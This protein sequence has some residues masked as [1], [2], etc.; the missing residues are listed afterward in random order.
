MVQVSVVD[1]QL[2]VHPDLWT[3]VDEICSAAGVDVGAFWKSMHELIREFA[4]RNKVCALAAR[5]PIC[6]R[7]RPPRSHHGAVVAVPLT[8]RHAV[9]V[10]PLAEWSQELLEE[11][12]AIQEQ[13]D[14]WYLQRAGV[15]IDPEEYSEFLAEIGYIVPEV[16]AQV[17]TQKVDPEIARIAGPQLVCP[18]D[19]ARFALNAANA[20]W[21]SLLDAY[22]GTDALPGEREGPY[23]TE[24]G[25]LVFDAAES[26]LDETWPLERPRFAVTKARYS[27]VRKFSA[28]DK[29]GTTRLV[30]TLGDGT[31]LGLTKP[32]SF[33]GYN[34]T[35]S[36]ELA[37]I[38]LVH[39][40]LHCQIHIDPDDAI[41][42]THPAGMKDCILESAVTTIM[43][44]EDSVAAVD[45][46]DKAQVRVALECP[47]AHFAAAS[48]RAAAVA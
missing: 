7:A 10:L 11:R 19:N 42:S 45:A 33:I 35:D 38:L 14:T 4:P 12:D 43:D 21:G 31:E 2:L 15:P 44:C 23:N 1:G 27:D 39:N 6:G 3:V 32:D 20:R 46:T 30:C 5:S 41:G 9:A 34:L 40:D 13:L 47:P 8:A 24:R 28:V 37:A 25:R 22:Y 17:T 48:Q 36:G 26:F 18:V 16:I 29:G